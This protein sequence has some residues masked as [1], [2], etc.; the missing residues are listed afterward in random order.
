MGL[1]ALLEPAAPVQRDAQGCV[2]PTSV[3]EDH[4][5]LVGLW[6]LTADGR[7]HERPRTE[8]AK[9]EPPRSRDTSW[10]RVLC[11]RPGWVRVELSYRQPESGHSE[12][13][14]AALEKG[15]WRLTKLEPLTI[16]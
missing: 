4:L 16:Q 5:Q 13:F 11:A 14:E 7:L 15:R 2:L 10:L 12:A 3:R 6:E 1:L 8:G 9:R